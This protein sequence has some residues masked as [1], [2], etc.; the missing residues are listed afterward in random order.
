MTTITTPPVRVILALRSGTNRSTPFWAV[1]PTHTNATVHQSITSIFAPLFNSFS[2]ILSLGPAIITQ[3]TTTNL[4]HDGDTILVECPTLTQSQIL[5]P[6]PTP[7]QLPSPVTAA[8]NSTQSP[9]TPPQVINSVVIPAPAAPTTATKSAPAQ[10]QTTPTPALPPSVSAIFNSPYVTP[11]EVTNPVLDL[12]PVV[13]LAA[14]SLNNTSPVT[15]T[16]FSV[17]AAIPSGRLYD[18][19][20][21]PTPFSSSV[22]Q[23]TIEG[24]NAASLELQQIIKR[25]SRHHSQQDKV[26]SKKF[27]LAH[28][29]I[30]DAIAARWS[31]RIAKQHVRTTQASSSHAPTALPP[32]PPSSAAPIISVVT[33]SS[34]PPVSIPVSSLTHITH[35]QQRQNKAQPKAS[36]A[37]TAAAAAAIEQKRIT[38]QE[39]KDRVQALR[40]ANASRPPTPPSAAEVQHTSIQAANARKHEVIRLANERN[41]IASAARHAVAAAAAIA[42]AA[43][44]ATDTAKA[45]A[46]DAAA[47]A[48]A[49]AAD[50]AAKTAAATATAKATA[51]AAAA[52]ATAADV[53]AKTAAATATAKAAAAASAAN[54]T[55]VDVAAK[56]AASYATA[57]ATDAA[58]ATTNA[59][60]SAP[61]ATIAIASTATATTITAADLVV[62][63]TADAITADI[64][65]LCPSPVT[66]IPAETSVSSNSSPESILG[67]GTGL[68]SEREHRLGIP[69]LT[70]PTRSRFG[71]D[72][73][74]P[75][76]LS[77]FR[78]L[79]S[80]VDIA[81]NNITDDSKIFVSGSFNNWGLDDNMIPLI[82]DPDYQHWTTTVQLHEGVNELICYADGINGKWFTIPSC[83]I[84]TNA[85]GT[86]SN[87]ITIPH[88]DTPIKI[89]TPPIQSTADLPLTAII[90][91]RYANNICPFAS[92]AVVLAIAA[93]HPY[94]HLAIE[95]LLNSFPT[96]QH[97]LFVPTLLR[98]IRE[99]ATYQ[100]DSLTI[101][102]QRDLWTT[103]INTALNQMKHIDSTSKDPTFYAHGSGSLETLGTI[104]SVSN[105]I[106]GLFH[107]AFNNNCTT[108]GKST[109]TYSN[110]EL[111][112][113]FENWLA[114]ARLLFPVIEITTTCTACGTL[115]ISKLLMSNSTA[116]TTDLP[117]YM[118]RRLNPTV[119]HAPTTSTT[120]CHSCK[121]GTIVSRAES[122]HINGPFLIELSAAATFSTNDT[123]YCMNSAHHNV[124]L[125]AAAA[126]VHTPGHFVAIESTGPFNHNIE[127]SLNKQGT[128]AHENIMNALTR[129][130]ETGDLT[131]I[132]FQVRKTDSPPPHGALIPANHRI[133]SLSDGHISLDSSHASPT[134]AIDM[135]GISDSE[136]EQNRTT[137]AT[138]TSHNAPLLP[139]ALNFSEGTGQVTSPSYDASSPAPLAFPTSS[140]RNVPITSS[141]NVPTTPSPQYI[142]SSLSPISPTAPT[143]PPLATITLPSTPTTSTPT[144]PVSVV[145]S[146]APSSPQPPS[147]PTSSSLVKD[148]PPVPET[149]TSIPPPAP[150]TIVSTT[151]T[152]ATALRRSSRVPVPSTKSL[153]ASESPAPLPLPPTRGRRNSAT[154]TRST[155]TATTVARS[156]TEKAGIAARTR[157]NSSKPSASS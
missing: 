21:P 53:A 6:T 50:V 13:P 139:T 98:V 141:L 57:T 142:T 5:L 19:Q 152:T 74:T 153:S 146:A 121:L 26:L 95:T 150:D 140:S 12:A 155:N 78:I 125:T 27:I 38:D 154:E 35:S 132:L 115:T 127:D 44:A 107:L 69:M 24:A 102:D 2:P 7:V 92:A 130:S 3:N 32:P 22:N 40:S 124:T 149:T 138:I 101:A 1:I 60:A 128:P 77:P 18:T 148:T 64:A 4:L 85:Q 147:L 131:A 114:L 136:E 103:D 16:I 104:Q 93:R 55:A 144:D 14:T 23:L 96:S 97:N 70:T 67:A 66:K 119:C 43:T 65:S 112:N 90:G 46:A 75:R 81:V 99:M 52:T 42:A 76:F 68:F 100:I 106:S 71:A 63:A 86:V 34:S 62:A 20:R 15:R 129:F 36:S 137:A 33:S 61:A 8:S 28:H 111:Q 109:S 49:T 83:D 84:I 145:V 89:L 45:D 41:E 88:I 116:T 30:K 143:P 151:T 25:T 133:L 39:E 54:A 110:V 31:R 72:D 108:D 9:V 80:P 118:A 134:S 48:T 56:T 58:A 113:I 37:A 47:A 157:S 105:V 11:Q 10:A 94:V 122:I 79:I 91:P 117:T 29:M 17:S 156:G 120:K 82:F 73:T 126:I 59:D 51:A 135:T 123:Q 87:T